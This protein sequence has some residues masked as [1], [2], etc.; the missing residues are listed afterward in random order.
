MQS[1][2]KVFFKI[3]SVYYLN[4]INKLKI[5]F[6]GLLIKKKKKTVITIL[7]SIQIKNYTWQ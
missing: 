3:I 6:T 2:F 7:Y 1:I 5:M 4:L